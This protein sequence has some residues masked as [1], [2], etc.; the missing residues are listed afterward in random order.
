MKALDSKEIN[1]RRL[2]VRAAGDKEK[3][4]GDP[5]YKD[6]EKSERASEMTEVDLSSVDINLIGDEKKLGDR[7]MDEPADSV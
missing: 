1:G 4:P 3:K 2:R 6:K 5:G 7:E